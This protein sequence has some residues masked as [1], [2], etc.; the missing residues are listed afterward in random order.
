MDRAQQQTDLVA[1][2][3]P[4]RTH[5]IQTKPTRQSKL[6]LVGA[7]ENCPLFNFKRKTV[8]DEIID[9]HRENNEGGG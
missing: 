2:R 5:H 3:T 8:S 9:I 4:N 6:R 7:I 1:S